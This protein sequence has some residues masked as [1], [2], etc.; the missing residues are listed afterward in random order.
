MKSRD[1]RGLHTIAYQLK[2][3]QTVLESIGY[4]DEINNGINLRKM[5][6]LLPFHLRAR[7]PEV[8]DSIQESGQRPRT[9]YISSFV[10]EK[11]RRIEGYIG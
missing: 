11:I 5:R 4:L 9:H 1:R 3:C 6:D 7:W 10:C 2:D 8:A